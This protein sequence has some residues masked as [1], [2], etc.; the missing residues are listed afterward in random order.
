ML[1][2]ERCTAVF[3]GLSA[4]VGIEVSL[5]REPVLP[6]DF[7]TGAEQLRMGNRRL[8]R[9]SIAPAQAKLAGTRCCPQIR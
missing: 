8:W 1:I 4:E 3:L 2:F 5:G 6:F 9:K 7:D